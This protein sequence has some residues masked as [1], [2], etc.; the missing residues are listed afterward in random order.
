MKDGKRELYEIWYES[1]LPA[2]GWRV[3]MFDYVAQFPTKEAAE[4]YVKMVK[5]H[6]EKYGTDILGRSYDA[7]RKS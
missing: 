2:R 7:P 1:W 6:R 3:Q 5:D 4:K